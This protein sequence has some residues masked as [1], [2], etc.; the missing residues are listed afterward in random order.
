MIPFSGSFFIQHDPVNADPSVFRIPFDALHT[1]I[2]DFFR[3]QI[4]AITFA[5]SDAF[6]VVKY[7]LTVNSH[8]D[9]TPPLAVLIIHP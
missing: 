4:T 5:A 1:V 8:F 7:T 3:V 6:P 9:G 2:T